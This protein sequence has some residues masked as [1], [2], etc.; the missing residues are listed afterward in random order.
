M[1]VAKD[2]KIFVQ[3]RRRKGNA[4]RGKSWTN[5]LRSLINLT[6]LTID[7]LEKKT[8][9]QIFFKKRKLSIRMSSFMSDFV[10]VV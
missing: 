3:Y 1:R 5:Y 2:V 4:L 10:L 9:L 7:N 6:Y 8:V